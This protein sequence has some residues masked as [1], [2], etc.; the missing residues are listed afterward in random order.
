MVYIIYVI[1]YFFISIHL[2]SCIFI[3]L[4]T[5]SHQ[6]WIYINNLESSTKGDIYI[7]S[8]YYI[9]ATVFTIGYDDI[10]SISI[11]ERFFNLILLVV[12]I[13]IYSFLVSALSNYVQSVDSKTLDYRN[14]IETLEQIRLTHQ[15][16]P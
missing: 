6:N 16:M 2:L 1:I 13:M 7:A 14:K 11:Y 8:L 5:L 9:C 3:F 10:V 12:R 15:K 4:S